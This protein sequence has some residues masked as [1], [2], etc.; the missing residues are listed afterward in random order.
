MGKFNIG[1]IVGIPSWS[2]LKYRF[3]EDYQGNI[4]MECPIA[5]GDCIEQMVHRTFSRDKEQFCLRKYEIKSTV[6]D[7]DYV[8]CD[9]E[10]KKE[11]R[12]GENWL[13]YFPE[14]VLE[15]VSKAE[16][17][18]VRKIFIDVK[19]TQ[20]GQTVSAEVVKAPARKLEKQESTYYI[21]NRYHVTFSNYNSL[22]N[23]KMGIA[24]SDCDTNEISMFAYESEQEAQNAVYAFSNMIDGINDILTESFNKQNLILGGK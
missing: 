22:H 9:I 4:R 16:D 24:F 17:A 18:A 20:D 15:L 13:C 11:I 6:S 23:K 10:T 2:T 8:L 12:Y 19:F 1:D 5:I 7:C 3:C 14:P 21:A